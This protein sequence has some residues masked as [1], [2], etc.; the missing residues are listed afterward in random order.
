MY[1]ESFNISSTEETDSQG[2][3]RIVSQEEVQKEVVY[4]DEGDE[5]KV[6]IQK[7]QNAKI[8]GAIVTA[9]GARKCCS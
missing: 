4:E 9:E 8:E 2:A 7:V 3:T 5:K 1:D 6:L